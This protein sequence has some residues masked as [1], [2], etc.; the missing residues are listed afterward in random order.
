MRGEIAKILSDE[1]DKKA[2]EGS[3]IQWLEKFKIKNENGDPITFDRHPFLVEIYN[4]FTPFQVQEKCAQVGSSTAAI[5]KGLFLAKTRGYNIIHTLPTADFSAEFVKSKVD[6]IISV[7][8]DVFNVTKR[9]DSTRHKEMGAA[10]MFYRGTF[11]E[12]EGISISA[13]VLVNDEYDRSNLANIDTF[14]SRLD[15]SDYKRKWIFSNPTVPGYGVNDMFER[16]NQYH[17]FIKCTHCNEWQYMKFPESIDFEKEMF[18]C[19]KCGKEVTDEDR[20]NGLWV[21]KY[22]NRDFNGYTLSQ[23]FC[24]WHTAASIKQKYIKQ[25]RD[26]FYNFTLGLP[27]AGGDVVVK[28][29]H[30]ARCITPNLPPADSHKVMGVD[31]GSKFHIAVGS[32][33]GIEQLSV[34]ESWDEVEKRIARVDPVICIIDGLPETNQVK[35]LQQVFG[36]TKIY[37][38]FYRDKP[39]DPHIYRFERKTTDKRVTAVYIDRFRSIG[40]VMDKITKAK[41]TIFSHGNDAFLEALITHF[42]SM[43]RTEIQNKVGQTYY[44]WKSSSKNDHFVHALN[45]MNV[46]LQRIFHLEK[47]KVHSEEDDKRPYAGFETPEER[48]GRN[49]REFWGDDIPYD[50]Y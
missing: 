20:I 45:Y 11:T 43:Y 35:K 13:D 23:L 31:Q 14:E 30:I 9:T 25:K 6:P 44:A 26:V 4:D 16:S 15:Y 7:N 34:V 37:P 10:H 24:T 50:K 1:M 49:D 40:D 18:C 12:K 2:A 32:H 38:A 46:A 41:V 5:L 27:Y 19:I 28:R 47:M 22:K 33:A 48:M 36:S 42:E 29:E 3:I 39:A 8:S 17:W 21:A